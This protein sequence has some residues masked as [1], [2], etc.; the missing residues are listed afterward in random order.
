RRTACIL[1]FAE[2]ASQCRLLG[3]RPDRATP[4]SLLTA[5][6]TAQLITVQNSSAT[7]PPNPSLRTR[8]GFWPYQNST[9]LKT[10]ATVTESLTREMQ[11][12]RVC[13]CGLMKTT[14]AFLSRMNCTPCLCWEWCPLVLTTMCPGEQISLETFSMT[15]PK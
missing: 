3:Q 9:N 13:C 8:T 7:T 11:F 1:T 14:T 12:S 15:V 10:A 2:T 5:M 4:F 6:A